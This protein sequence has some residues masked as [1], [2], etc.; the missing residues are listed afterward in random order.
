MHIAQ[1][2]SRSH[3][4]LC[5]RIAS[6]NSPIWAYEENAIHQARNQNRHRGRA[7]RRLIV[8][9]NLVRPDPYQHTGT[10]AGIF[11]RGQSWGAKELMLSGSNH[12]SRACL[13]LGSKL[14]A[15][16]SFDEKRWRGYWAWERGMIQ[17]VR[18][19]SAPHLGRE[20]KVGWVGPAS[21]SP[22]ERFVSPS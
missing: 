18:Q 21:P 4:T 20:E 8:S 15:R 13:S 16:S 7:V 22:S 12:F 9:V 10:I 14:A 1:L 5:P 11:G 6:S 3:L 19:G 17:H 2:G